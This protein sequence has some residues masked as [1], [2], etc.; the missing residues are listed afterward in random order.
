MRRAARASSGAML[1]SV[2]LC[3]IVAL[4]AASPGGAEGAQPN[5]AASELGDGYIALHDQPTSD[6]TRAVELEEAPHPEPRVI[7]TVPALTGAHS[8]EK[9]Q[10]SARETWGH[11]VRCYKRHAERKTGNV[12]LK[13]DIA[14]SGKVRGVQRVSTTLDP[15]VSEC[16]GEAMRNK[17]M[18]EAP[19]RSLATVEIRLAP[20]DA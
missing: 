17:A 7:V 16:V 3:A 1:R 18:P 9:V 8:R 19:G 14:G 10:R 12:V 20:G 5:A 4:L 15:K 13:L 11:L 2:S 6:I